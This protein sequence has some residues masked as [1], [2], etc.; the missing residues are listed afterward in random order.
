M[1]PE[2]VTAVSEAKQDG[3]A[4]KPRGEPDQ[5]PGAELPASLER[6]PL[7]GEA[8]W[9]LFGS[10]GLRA[11]WSIL[12]FAALLFIF[13]ELFGTV[14]SAVVE[15]VL[16]L[17]IAGGTALSTILGEGEWVAALLASGL[18][19]ARVE[20]RS[21]LDFHLA[22]SQ[23]LIHFCSGVAAGFLA[24]SVLVGI[25]VEGGWM[26][27][28]AVALS[29][30]QIVE[31]G[32]LWGVGFVLVGLTEEGMFRCYLQFTLSRGVN[33]WWALGIVGSM[34]LYLLLTSKGHGAWGVYAMALAG[35]LPC[36]GVHLAG[37]GGGNFW[38]AAWVT[39]TAFG[40]IHTSNNG[41]NWIGIFAAA[42]IGFVFC[43]SVRVT[44]SAWWAI[45]CHASWDWAESYFYG[46]ADSG[47]AA[48]GHYLT[49]VPAGPAWWSGGTDG[50]EGSVL[51]LPVI[52]LLLAAVLALY[53]R[54]KTAAAQPIAE[55]VAG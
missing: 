52:V 33:F 43:V 35:L 40:F 20:H 27:F 55:R 11:G 30:A 44:G 53:G 7:A 17:K 31:Y 49:T 38:Q 21:L 45:G 36:L 26:H 48:K 25:L 13:V 47:F 9:L 18:T 10:R 2:H 22:D 50:P 4:E 28:G 12:L 51:V 16:H 14:L 24:L 5:M 37:T 41:E 6:G 3:L 54:R 46:T 34:C 1:E 8:H 32:A 29:G 42:A 23:P 39:S 19:V 15:N